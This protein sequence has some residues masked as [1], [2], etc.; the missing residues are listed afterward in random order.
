M[1]TSILH[2][3]YHLRPQLNGALKSLH[4]LLKS[5]LLQ[6]LPN[7]LQHR[8]LPPP[9]IIPVLNLI[10]SPRRTLERLILPNIRL[11]THAVVL[12]FLQKRQPS[13]DYIRMSVLDLDKATHGDALKIFLR[14]LEDEV[15]AGDGPA[16]C[17]ARERDGTPRAETHVVGCAHGE[18]GEEEEVAD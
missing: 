7:L 1:H 2:K 6:Q 3:L 17:Y 10:P 16:F 9:P 15:G 11:H 4:R 13:L 8:T 12:V 5:L 18:V 14:F